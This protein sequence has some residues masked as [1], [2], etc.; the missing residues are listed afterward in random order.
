MERNLGS[1]IFCKAS[2]M[3]KIL[4][5]RLTF[6]HVLYGSYV[7]HFLI[8]NLPLI[9]EITRILLGKPRALVVS[10]AD[11]FPVGIFITDNSFRFILKN[12]LQWNTKSLVEISSFN[13]CLGATQ[14]A[15]TLIF[16]ILSIELGG[17]L[18]FQLHPEYISLLTAVVGF[19]SVRRKYHTSQK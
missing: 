6:S 2:R 8:C 10:L 16:S 13:V 15:I 17:I 18:F 5:N 7:C 19:W 9:I 1:E 14:I 3:H 12:L 11:D 4:L